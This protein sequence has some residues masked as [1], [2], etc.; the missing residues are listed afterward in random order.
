MNVIIVIETKTNF[1]EH[2]AENKSDEKYCYGVIWSLSIKKIYFK[3]GQVGN[4]LLYIRCLKK[5]L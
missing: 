5:S 3:N 4:A 1:I 2:Y